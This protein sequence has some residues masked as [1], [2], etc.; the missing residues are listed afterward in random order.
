MSN[1]CFGE[2]KKWFY[3]KTPISTTQ[4]KCVSASVKVEG[5]IY[6]SSKASN[7]YLINPLNSF[8]TVGK[9]TL[10]SQEERGETGTRGLYDSLKVTLRAC[11]RANS[12]RLCF[13][14]HY[15]HHKTSFPSSL[16]KGWKKYAM[17]KSNFLGLFSFFFFF[18]RIS[19]C[20]KLMN[21]LDYAVP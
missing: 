12:A 3:W 2:K 15:H 5:Y 13:L 8:L 17:G 6:F 11:V 7:K 19:V 1:Q 16:L 20:K 18:L 4:N 9:N 10:V 14:I 21:H